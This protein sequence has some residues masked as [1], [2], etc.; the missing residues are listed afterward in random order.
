LLQSWSNHV[1]KNGAAMGHGKSRITTKS[2][3]PK[4]KYALE[5]I[6]RAL[7]LPKDIHKTEAE[8][9]EGI[10]AKMRGKHPRP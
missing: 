3:N 7:K 8:I 4:G 6:R 2:Q 1:I 10:M 5:A 9:R